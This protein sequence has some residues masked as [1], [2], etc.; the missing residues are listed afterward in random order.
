MFG[1]LEVSDTKGKDP[2][3][4]SRVGSLMSER[5]MAP[6]IWLR[7]DGHPWS[8]SWRKSPGNARMSLRKI[9]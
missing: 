6:D 8:L 3:L 1:A 5:Q 7:P 4:T 9:D 2:A